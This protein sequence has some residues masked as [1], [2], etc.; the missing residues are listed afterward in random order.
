V[1]PAT[2]GEVRQLTTGS[3]WI[4]FRNGLRMGSD[5]FSLR[6]VTMASTVCGGCL[7]PGDLPDG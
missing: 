2:G 3:T 5:C 7:L 1:M 6:I 4:S